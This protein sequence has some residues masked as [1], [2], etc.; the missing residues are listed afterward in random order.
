MNFSLQFPNDR[1][2]FSRMN[3]PAEDTSARLV[4]LIHEAID[5]L[6]KKVEYE[7]CDEV[8]H[9]GVGDHEAGTRYG[10]NFHF[11]TR[12]CIVFS[13]QR[14]VAYPLA[15]FPWASSHAAAKYFV[16]LVSEGKCE[17]NW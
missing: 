11:S 4:K 12:I 5:S 9:Y 7:L 6:E 10:L 15:V 2:D 16:W 8:F 14:D 17:I 3:F 13:T 1:Y